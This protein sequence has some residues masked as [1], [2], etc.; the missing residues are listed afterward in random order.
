MSK[1]SGGPWKRFN[2]A[3]TKEI[4]QG[5]TA[6]S[7][8]T[9]FR[10]LQEKG[11][12][13][14]CWWG[15]GA[16]EQGRVAGGRE[17]RRLGTAMALWVSNAS[18]LQQPDAGRGSPITSAAFHTWVTCDGEGKSGGEEGTKP[19]CLSGLRTRQHPTIRGDLALLAFEGVLLGSQL[20]GPPCLGRTMDSPLLWGVWRRASSL[21]TELRPCFS[22]L[23]A[24]LLLQYTF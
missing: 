2:L 19:S 14:R 16:R 6:N 13:G 12:E 11:L 9:V 15:G 4:A 10:V 18:N 3:I 8:T 21:H 22:P 20:S 24:V 1:E 5:Q 7:P 17:T 23:C